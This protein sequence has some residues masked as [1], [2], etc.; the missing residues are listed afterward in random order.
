MKKEATLLS[1]FTREG[2]DIKMVGDGAPFI[3]SSP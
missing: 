2:M 1:T 3:G